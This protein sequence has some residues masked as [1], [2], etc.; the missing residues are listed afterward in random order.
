[1]TICRRVALAA[2]LC[3]GG[4]LALA[5]ECVPDPLPSEPTGPGWGIT[6]NSWYG[7]MEVFAWRIA[8]DDQ[9][10]ELMV[11][12]RRGS[13]G[14]ASMCG[15][16]VRVRQGAL[17]LT[18]FRLVRDPP[19]D[20]RLCGDIADGVTVQLKA[21][22]GSPFDDD[23]AFEL[24][25]PSVAGLYTTLQVPAYKPESYGLGGGDRVLQEGLSGTWYNAHLGGEGVMMEFGDAAGIAMLFLTWYT[26]DDDGN[27]IWIVA[28]GNYPQEADAL[29]LVAHTTRGPRFG[30]A[31]RSEDLQYQ[32]WGR[33]SV[34]FASC[35][36]AEL[37]YRR[38]DGTEGSKWMTRGLSTR[39]AAEC[40]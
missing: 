39:N 27:P 5:A 19:T 28:S 17:A 15:D 3:A 13:S 1:M 14:P 12:F 4:S 10:A 33:L 24:D 25:L 6:Y 34:R 32:E 9:S 29:E 21:P 16:M 38:L 18:G 37:S 31:F 20:A 35:I 2:F 30:D 40:R 26:Y 36:D 7:D 22:P 8:C 23:E 11:R